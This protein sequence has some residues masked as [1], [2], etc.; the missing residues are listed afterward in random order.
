MK[1]V[2]N[3]V[4]KTVTAGQAIAMF[5]AGIATVYILYDDNTESMVGSLEDIEEAVKTGEYFGIEVGHVSVFPNHN[6][7][8]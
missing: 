7:E 5:S 8:N 6:K 2:D 1:I 3:F 4:W